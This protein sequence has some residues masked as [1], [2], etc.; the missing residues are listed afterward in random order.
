MRNFLCV[1]VKYNFIRVKA[2][3]VFIAVRNKSYAASASLPFIWIFPVWTPA[4]EC[5]NCVFKVT[6]QCN[7]PV[8]IAVF[9]HPVIIKRNSIAK[10]FT[11]N[12]QQDFRSICWIKNKRSFVTF[13]ICTQNCSCICR[14]NRIISCFRMLHT[15][16]RFFKS[17]WRNIRIT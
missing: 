5:V 16:R 11:V 13:N 3:S 8:I 15:N 6:V 4:A 12:F 1:R 7:A 2:V 9:F 14:R 10:R 17:P